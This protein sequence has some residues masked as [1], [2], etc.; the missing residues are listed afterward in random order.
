[1]RAALVAFEGGSKDDGWKTVSNMFGVNVCSKA[2][3]VEDKSSLVVCRGQM[4]M[5]SDVTMPL[6]QAQFIKSYNNTESLTQQMRA[7]GG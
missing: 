7:S 2:K 1:M 4:P 3:P 5:S 6:L